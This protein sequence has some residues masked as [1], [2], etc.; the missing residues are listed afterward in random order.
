MLCLHGTEIKREESHDCQEVYQYLSIG[1]KVIP[2][3]RHCTAAKYR[4]L[5]L[6]SAPCIFLLQFYSLP[7]P[8]AQLCIPA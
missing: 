8:T 1:L 4:G 3:T 2:L 6:T 5:P 7:C